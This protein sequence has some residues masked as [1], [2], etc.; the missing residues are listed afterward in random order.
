MLFS[1]IP[2]LLGCLLSISAVKAVKN[3][4]V[5]IIII[6]FGCIPTICASFVL[7]IIVAIFIDY[8]IQ[9]NPQA[10]VYFPLNAAIKNT[11][12]L[13]PKMIHCPRTL[14]DLIAIQPE[15][16]MSYLNQ[17]HLT[18]SYYPETNKYTLIARYNKHWA[19]IFD[20]RLKNDSTGSPDFVE[21]KVSTCGKDHIANPPNFPG[22]WGNIGNNTK[23]SPFELK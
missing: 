6:A 12:Y 16:F 19:V 20:S 7:S 3:P 13:D 2:L 15:D 18:Y 5:K 23:T 10:S 22:P 17:A 9:P 11:C 21:V 4:G 8:K 14:E 1:F